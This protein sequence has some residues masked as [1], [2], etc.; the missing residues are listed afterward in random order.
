MDILGRRLGIRLLIGT[1]FNETT[2]EGVFRLV[3]HRRAASTR[4]PGDMFA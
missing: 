1:E 4:L 2:P 3:P